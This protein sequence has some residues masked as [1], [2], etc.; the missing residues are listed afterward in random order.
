MMQ[1]LVSLLKRQTFLPPIGCYWTTGGE[2]VP[3]RRTIEIFLSDHIGRADAGLS[4]GHQP[5]PDQANN[6]HPVDAKAARGLS[7]DQLMPRRAFALAI[8][9]NP[10]R[11]AEVS[12]AQLGPALA[13]SRAYS[14]PVEKWGD[15][16]VRQAAS[17]VADQLHGL[18]IGFPAILTSPVFRDFKS[19]VI[20]ALPMQHE[21]QPAGLHC[22]DDLF[23]D[24]S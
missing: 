14:E 12:D 13:F 10:M 3:Y 9:R 7:Q 16:V 5:V 6:S 19:R 8:D 21:T 24:R 4:R 1:Y 11:A 20:A 18:D 23:Q 15:T 2:R 22:D 17:E